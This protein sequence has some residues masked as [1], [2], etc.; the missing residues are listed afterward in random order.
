[1][2]KYKIFSKHTYYID[3]SVPIDEEKD[4]EPK[5]KR[6]KNRG[7]TKSNEK[8]D[9]KVSEWS[10]WSPCYSCKGYRT[11]SRDILVI[12]FYCNKIFNNK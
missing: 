9:C 12:F 8:V 7:E 3:L 4:S 1:M 10:D 5:R 11:M 6:K 2:P